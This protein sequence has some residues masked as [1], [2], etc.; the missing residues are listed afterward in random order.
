MAPARAPAVTLAVLVRK[1]GLGSVEVM[2]LHWATA[3][4]EASWVVVAEQEAPA[5]TAGASGT[6][7]ALVATAT[8]VGAMAA[9]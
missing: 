3:C 2:A 1:V 4:E 7:A 6:A 8:E 5:G 9:A